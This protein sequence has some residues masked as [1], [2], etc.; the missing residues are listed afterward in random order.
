LEADSGPAPA[1]AAERGESP[2]LTPWPA[3]A[4]VD[5][6]SPSGAPR[7]ERREPGPASAQADRVD[8]APTSDSLEPS[9]PSLAEPPRNARSTPPP[10]DVSRLSPQET[11]PAPRFDR[12]APPIAAAD[13]PRLHIGTIEVRATPPQ[14]PAPGPAPEKAASRPPA[15]GRIG[16]AYAWRFGLAQG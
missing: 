6:A 1:H 2:A 5:R 8:R 16:R 3:T 9:A 14:V 4:S 12:A 7:A 11:A 15:P 10:A 13:P